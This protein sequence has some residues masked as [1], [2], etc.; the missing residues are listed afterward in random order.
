MMHKNIHFGILERNNAEPIFIEGIDFF[1]KISRANFEFNTFLPTVGKIY[2]NPHYLM[3]RKTMVG[4][5]Y[6][7]RDGVAQRRA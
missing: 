3:T 6:R 4:D 5:S 7:N 2:P 1:N